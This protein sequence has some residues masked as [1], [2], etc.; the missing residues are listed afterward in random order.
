M[1][2]ELEIKVEA[3]K[4]GKPEIAKHKNI[5][6]KVLNLE[7]LAGILP[8]DNMLRTNLHIN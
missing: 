7:H 2:E 3:I 5:S 1:S 8:R 4:G 6:K